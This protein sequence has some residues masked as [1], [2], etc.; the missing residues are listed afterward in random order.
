MPRFVR[1]DAVHVPD[2]IPL[3]LHTSGGYVLADPVAVYTTAQHTLTAE[4]FKEN[5][6][7][8]KKYE[9]GESLAR[10]IL[11]RRGKA[12]S[13]APMMCTESVTNDT[14]HMAQ[15]G[16]YRSAMKFV[17]KHDNPPPPR[18]K[19]PPPPQQHIQDFMQKP[20]KYDLIT[21]AEGHQ[22]K[23]GWEEFGNPSVIRRR[24]K[25]EHDPYKQFVEYTNIE[26]VAV[27]LRQGKRIFGGG[28][29]ACST[30]NTAFKPEKQEIFKV[31]YKFPS[32]SAP[33]MPRRT[34]SV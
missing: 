9:K 10:R 14:S 30:E 21:L 28:K 4:K 16:V 12:V 18:P 13:P 3:Y 7:K 26:D 24:K 22:V 2:K 17:G 33:Y 19:T 34:W 11:H 1:K 27:N 5:K 8:V 32:P 20:R 31:C 23:T 15:S 29:N 25:D 6:L